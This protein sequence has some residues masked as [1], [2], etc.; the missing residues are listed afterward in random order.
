MPFRPTPKAG[1]RFGVVQ[2]RFAGLVEYRE[3][4][5]R[6]LA[7]LSITQTNDPVHWTP[8]TSTCGSGGTSMTQNQIAMTQKERPTP[9][10]SRTQPVS[11]Q[12]LE[13]P[14]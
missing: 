6:S 3:F 14:R 7:F 11:W 2:G 9:F 8:R 4:H 10:E 12:R 1:S 5:A 13:S